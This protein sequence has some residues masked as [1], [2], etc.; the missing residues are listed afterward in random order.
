MRRDCKTLVRVMREVSGE[1]PA[2]WGE[3]MVGFGRRA[4]AYASGCSGE[5]FLIGF[6]PRSQHLSIYLTCGFVSLEAPLRRLGKFKTGRGCLNI[7]RLDEIDQEVLA[8]MLDR[9]VR[10]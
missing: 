2:M 6:S 9:A 4:Y 5:S 7:K 8:S 1:A 3:S 10:P